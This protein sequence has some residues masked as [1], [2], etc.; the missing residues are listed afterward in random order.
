M[1]L[2]AIGYLA[3]LS[4]G[5]TASPIV[6][7]AIAEIKSITPNLATV[8]AVDAT[9]LQ[10]PNATEEMLPGLVKPGTLD[11][12]GNF[13]GD[14][15][16]LAILTD[17]TSRTVYPFQVTWKTAAGVKTATLTGQGFFTKFDVAAIE[18]SKVVEFTAA[19]QITGS[20]TLVAA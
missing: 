18:A 1:T 2:A 15:T 20:E 16:Q 6:Y 12:T 13:T 8:P 5:N 10:S 7:T 9:H 17:M 4:I 3:T 19:I 14:A 11:F